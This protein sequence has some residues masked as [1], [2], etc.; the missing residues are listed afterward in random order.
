MDSKFSQLLAGL[1]FVIFSYLFIGDMMKITKRDL[2][3]IIKK[4]FQFEN[5]CIYMDNV[6]ISLKIVNG[7]L[8]V[9]C[10]QW[11]DL[12]KLFLR[13]KKYILFYPM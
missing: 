2:E 1:F 10:N 9:Q 4:D 13:S 3:V 5:Q 7:A 8:V 11:I 6:P 12:L